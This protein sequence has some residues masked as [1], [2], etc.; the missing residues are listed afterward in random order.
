MAEVVEV[1]SG[2]KALFQLTRFSPSVIVCNIR[3]PDMM[4]EELLQSIRLK[5]PDASQQIP[6]IAVAAGNREFSSAEAS[7][8]G[9]DGF[10][11]HPIDPEQLVAEILSL[12]GR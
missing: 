10:L 3:L 8:A 4:G 1:A 9:F 5:Q 7:T 11:S 2:F 6:V 12:V